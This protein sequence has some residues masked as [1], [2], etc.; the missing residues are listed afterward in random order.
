MNIYTTQ[1]KLL[2]IIAHSVLFKPNYSKLAR[3]LDI[4]RNAVSDLMFY[5]EKTGIINQLCNDTMGIKLLLPTSK[6]Q[7]S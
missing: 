6:S 7:N 4:N 1:K 5:I 3:D 2:Y